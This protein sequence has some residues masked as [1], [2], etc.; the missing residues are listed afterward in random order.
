[1]NNTQSM[2]FCDIRGIEL[3]SA[4]GKAVPKLK[5]LDLSDTLI[6]SGELVLYLLFQD[7]FQT[8]HEFMYLY[9]Y[10]VLSLEERMKL[11]K[12]TGNFRSIE[13]DN[14]SRICKHSFEH[15]CPWCYDEGA[16]D[17]NLRAGCSQEF[18][19]INVVDDKLWEF[20]ENME[21]DSQ[22]KESCL[23]QSISVSNLV[24]SISNKSKILLRNSEFLPYE[25]KFRPEKGT[26]KLGELDGAIYKPSWWFPPVDIVYDSIEDEAFG[27][28]KINPL[29]ESLQVLRVPPF[30]RSLWGELIPFLLKCCPNLKTLGKASGTMLGLDLLSKTEYEEPRETNLEEIFIHLDLLKQADYVESPNPSRLGNGDTISQNSPNLRFVVKNL[31]SSAFEEIKDD[32]DQVKLIKKEFA[33]DIWDFARTLLPHENV[34]ERLNHFVDLICSTSPKTRAI[35]ILSL[36]HIEGFNLR[37]NIEIW[38][39]FLSLKYFCELT[40]QINHLVEFAGLIKCVGKRLRKV[41]IA[42]MIGERDEPIISS[43][44]EGLDLEEQGALFIC[45]NCPYV[46]EMD[47]VSVNFIRK[48]FFGR[49]IEIMPGHFNRLSKLAVGKIDWNS[50]L[51]VWKLIPYMKELDIAVIVPIFT[52]NEQLFEEP[53]VLDIFDVQELFRVNKI[54]RNYLERLQVNTFRFA[55]FDAVVNFLLDFKKLKSVGNIDTETFNQNER[56]QMQVLVSR[57]EIE[58]GMS[59][60][61]SEVFD[62]L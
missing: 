4:I 47:L 52:L 56:S 40:L 17:D 54:I 61:L 59:V 31:G 27:I 58:R 41:C 38:E 8:L 24:K 12:Q 7:A 30:S 29:A 37:S 36:S 49:Q 46:E 44:F 33:L 28:Q 62:V 60:R 26:E 20:V 57:L 45:Q 10:K 39:K 1:L 3:F 14:E 19:S 6:F 5:V 11:F 43:E 18:L 2:M 23:L 22:L 55:T 16:F 42:E 32:D 50:L 48:F 9:K 34:G 21:F 51:Q 35:H 25:P 15:Y 53:K 13:R